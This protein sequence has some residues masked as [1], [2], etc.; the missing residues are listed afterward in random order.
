MHPD[1]V[2][3]LDAVLRA[4]KSVRA[5]RPDPVPRHRLVEILEAARAAPPSVATRHEEPARPL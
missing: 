3:I 1:A 2:S 5:F 4:R